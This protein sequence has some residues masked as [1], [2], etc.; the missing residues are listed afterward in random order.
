MNP[1]HMAVKRLLG[2]NYIGPVPTVLAQGPGI[3][4]RALDLCT[5]SGLWYDSC[6]FANSTGLQIF[7]RVDEMAEVFPH[8]RF[9][10]IDLGKKLPFINFLTLTIH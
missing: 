5:G 6:Y 1:L 4:R 8:V 2:G 10:G 3:R 9:Y 7:L